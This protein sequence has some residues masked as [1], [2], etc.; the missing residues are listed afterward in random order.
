[1]NVQLA[2]SRGGLAAWALLVVL[3]APASAQIDTQPLA[4]NREG[5]VSVRGNELIVESTVNDP[6]ALRLGSLRTQRGL[7]KL[8]F[9]L[10]NPR[11][12][13]VLMQGKQTEAQDGRTLAGQGGELTLH[14]QQPFKP[15]DDPYMKPVFSMTTDRIEFYVPITAPNLGGG[16]NGGGNWFLESPGGEYRTYMQADGNLVVYM[17]RNSWLCPTWSIFTGIIPPESLPQECR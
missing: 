8:S 11:C 16:G 2:R 13:V 17:I 14:L 15:C 7:G 9:D 1:M 12:E 4:D 6:S 5:K 10:L 3:A